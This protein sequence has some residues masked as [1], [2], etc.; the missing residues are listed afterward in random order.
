MLKTFFNYF[1]DLKKNIHGYEPLITINIDSLSIEKNINAL[2]KLAPNWQIAPVLKSNAY[3]HGTVLVAAI[4]RKIPN[5]PFLCVDSLFEANLLRANDIHTPLLIL[6]HTQM[7]SMFKTKG[8]DIS[9]TISSLEKLKHVCIENRKI[10]I[11]L[12]FDTGMHRQGIFPSELNTVH[13]LLQQGS[14]VSVVGVLSHFADAENLGSKITLSQIAIWN[15]LVKDIKQLLPRIKYFHISNSAGFKWASRIEANVGRSGIAVYGIDPGNLQ[16]PLNPS[17]SMFASVGEVRE[18]KKEEGVGYNHTFKA[19]RKTLVATVP[20]GYFEGVDRRLSSLGCFYLNNQ[21]APIIGRVS[22]NMSSCDVTKIKN[23]H[24]GTPVEIISSD[25]QKSN[26]V[27]NIAKICKTIP[28][29]I[30]VN[31]PGHLKRILV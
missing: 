19:K 29:E 6:G 7:E 11:Q 18:V 30:L 28:Y 23:V 14:N 15:K 25:P 9:F 16:I 1:R 24:L 12:K 8:Q 22:M 13:S 4:L 10:S 31:I 21:K 27:I 3:G 26:S 2:S 20:V 5:I 17:L